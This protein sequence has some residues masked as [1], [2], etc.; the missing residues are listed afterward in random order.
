MPTIIETKAFTF[1]ELSDA[2]KEKARDW[3]REGDTDCDFSH[4]NYDFIQVGNI[5]GIDFDTHEVRLMGGKSR[6][7]A[8]IYW[9][10]FSSQ[11]DG[12]CF[13]GTWRLRKESIEEIKAHAPEDKTLHDIAAQL[14]PMRFGLEDTLWASIKHRG[15]YYH[16]N[17]VSID[18]GEDDLEYVENEEIDT[19]ATDQIEEALRNFCRWMYRQLEA[20]NDW[21]YSDECVDDNIEANDYLFEE[22]G[23]F[24]R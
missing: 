4:L 20:E 15:S 22:D 12:A 10:G 7:E 17:S 24:I 19:G 6:S 13:E 21:R 2:A 16:E 14:W 9:S 11:G 3:F 1:D 8:N 23:S 18:I 5:L